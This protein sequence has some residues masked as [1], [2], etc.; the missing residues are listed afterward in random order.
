[1]A[2]AHVLQRHIGG[3]ISGV[4]DRPFAQHKG[5][6]SELKRELAGTL[7]SIFR[8]DNARNAVTHRVASPELV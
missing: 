8:Q 5:L 3:H 4:S 7:A 1:M 2:E 6:I